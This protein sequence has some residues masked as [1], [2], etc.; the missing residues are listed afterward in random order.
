M[1]L[2]LHMMDWILHVMELTLHMMEWTL[3]LIEWV[4][5]VMEW[6]LHMMGWTLYYGWERTRS[7]EPEH[8]QTK[9]FVL[10][11]FGKK[12][13]TSSNSCAPHNTRQ[14]LKSSSEYARLLGF[15]RVRPSI[16]ALP[17]SVAKQPFEMPLSVQWH[18]WYGFLNLL[19]KDHTWSRPTRT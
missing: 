6:T 14:T 8:A 15:A 7:S 9:I 10:G 17:I 11:L 19:V 16:E 3:H 18:Q 1:E 5:H 13:R 12:V 2:T 4:L